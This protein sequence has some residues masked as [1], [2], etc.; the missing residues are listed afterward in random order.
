MIDQYKGDIW[1]LL[2]T[3]YITI[4]VNQQGVM[5]AGL[6]LEAKQRF[7]ELCHRDRAVRKEHY[8]IYGEDAEAWGY[9][10]V[11]DDHPLIFFPTK[12]DWQK[13]ADITLIIQSLEKLA[14][15]IIVTAIFPEGT[16]NFA[17][18]RI[19]CGL[20]KL[21]WEEDVYPC[22]VDMHDNFLSKEIRAKIRLTLVEPSVGM[23]HGMRSEA[24]V[25]AG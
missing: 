16:F 21:N 22:V 13:P 4:P 8:R 15:K 14:S 10:L 19:G 18:P 24:N 17:M 1:D 23:Y 6:A 2:P 20:G 9:E 3:H 7:P 12:W 11:R 5:G 25:Q